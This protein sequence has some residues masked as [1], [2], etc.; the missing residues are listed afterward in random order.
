MA[1]PLTAVQEELLRQEIEGYL[2]GMKTA[3]LLKLQLAIAAA[4]AKLGDAIAI[5][6]HKPSS[7]DT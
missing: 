3:D 4:E 7:H 5:P 6:C 1:P 2:R